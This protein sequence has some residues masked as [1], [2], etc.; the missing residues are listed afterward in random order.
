[1]LGNTA[2]IIVATYETVNHC[3]DDLASTAVYSTTVVQLLSVELQI[4]ILVVKY[5]LDILV[6]L[7]QRH[8]SNT[9]TL[10]SRGNQ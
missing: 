9:H 5:V 2:L 10:Y 8:K 3:L 6:L 7:Y 1:M 4:F